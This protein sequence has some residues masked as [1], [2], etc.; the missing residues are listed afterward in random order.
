MISEIPLC[1]PIQDNEL[2]P[3]EATANAYKYAG[4]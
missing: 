1:I 3:L 4:D 2:K